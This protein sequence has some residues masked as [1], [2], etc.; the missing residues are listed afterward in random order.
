MIIMK[1]SLCI[2]TFYDDLIS[3]QKVNIVAGYPFQGIEFWSWR[4]KNITAL[5]EA[6]DD[7]NLKIVNFSGHRVGNFIDSREHERILSDFRDA[8]ETAETLGAETLMLLTNELGEEGRVVNPYPAL[9][10]DEKQRNLIDGLKLLC[11]ENGR[12]FHLVLEPLN[13]VKDHIGYYL[14]Q[15]DHA[16][17]IIHEVGSPDLKILCDLYHQGMVGDDPYR[18][19]SAYA[20]IIGHIHIADFPGRAEPGTSRGDWREILEHIEASGYKEWV[21]F[22]FFPKGDVSDALKVTAEIL[23]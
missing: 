7:H 3:E 4:D 15:M 18:T 12:K 5:K 11:A 10:D 17:E 1:Y 13:T 23:I 14:S 2:D 19:I 20:E 6:C 22:E 9:S 21:G 16:A 8:M